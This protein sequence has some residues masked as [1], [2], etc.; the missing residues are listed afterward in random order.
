MSRVRKSSVHDSFPI[1]GWFA[2]TPADFRRDFLALARR[3]SYPAGSA[4]FLA[5][6]A[7][8]D[9]FGLCSGVITLQSRVVHPDAALVHMMWPGEWFGTFSVLLG[10]GRRLSAFARTDVVLLRIPGEDL[11]ELLRRCPQWYPELWR[12]TVHGMDVAMQMAAD[13][14]IQS[15]PARCAA[16][17]LR[18]AGRRWPSSPEADLPVVIPASQHELAMY[19]N[20]SRNTFSRVVKDLSSRGLLSV[21]YKSLTLSDPARLR[22]I[23][24]AG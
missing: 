3:K 5:G 21:N 20:V 15:T 11:K 12:D 8:Q 9:V 24:D 4:I 14:L 13:L 1:R 17:L 7:G 6:E 23:A 16:V 10:K 2:E 18:I 19:C 22:E